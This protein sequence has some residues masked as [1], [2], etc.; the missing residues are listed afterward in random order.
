MNSTGT[1][2]KHFSRNHFFFL[3]SFLGC[4]GTEC[5]SFNAPIPTGFL[6]FFTFGITLFRPFLVTTL[7][8]GFAIVGG[9]TWF[10]FSSSLFSCCFEVL[11]VHSSET[12][13][14]CVPQSYCTFRLINDI[15]QVKFTRWV[16]F[17]RWIY[18]VCTFW[19]LQVLVLLSQFCCSPAL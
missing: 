16:L 12:Y 10:L 4:L 17:N 18:N 3:H 15:L 7:S 11:A 9:T 19:I 5:S 8:A 1:S 14:F 6:S 2:L 13:L